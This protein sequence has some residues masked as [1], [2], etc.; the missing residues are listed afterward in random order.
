MK[1]E[2]KKL[3]RLLRRIAKGEDV[4]EQEMLSH[5]RGLAGDH[6]F[7]RFI[8][9]AGGEAFSGWAEDKP[10]AAEKFRLLQNALARAKGIP[11][12]S[13]LSETLEDP[14]I[15]VAAVELLEQFG[16]V[17]ALTTLLEE[18]FGREQHQII[19]KAIYRL[20]QKGI[21]PS[22]AT[23]TQ[24]QSPREMFVFGENR[25]ARWQPIF[26]F[27]AHSA[28]TEA[29]DLFVL[30]LE[31]GRH[32]GPAEQRRDV[33]MDSKS[34]LELADRYSEGLE[35]QSGMKI[36]FHPMDPTHARFFLQKSAGLLKETAGERA[37]SD[38]LKFI[39]DGTAED[40]FIKFERKEGYVPDL[41]QASAVLEAPYFLH[42]VFITDELSE[43]IT[44]LEKMEQGP[45]VLPPAKLLEMRHAAANRWIEKYFDAKNRA[46]WSLAFAKAAYFLHDSDFYHAQSAW[47]ISEALQD[48]ETRI[49]RIPAVAFLLER[50][51]K[52]ILQEKKKQDEQ[53]KQTSLI[54]SPAE[55]AAQQQRKR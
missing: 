42:W 39:G 49:D 13:L 6:E 45:I 7:L 37:I 38:F 19:R 48:A 35:R 54:M 53:E 30:Q 31:E 28:Y 20:K 41:Q 27:R 15:F 21:T 3:E 16:N 17:S 12:N 18:P 32:F 8:N 10:A 26:Y 14:L 4:S 33:Q 36:G 11:G 46:V 50:S 24:Y 47:S 22:E 25:L 5:W 34:L 43:F 29:G 1:P 51:V 55:F 23:S 2:Q 52:L 44:E 9:K 40:P